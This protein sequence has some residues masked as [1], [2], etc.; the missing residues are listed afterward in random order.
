MSTR[1]SLEI[2]PD[3]AALVREKG[4][5]VYISVDGAGME[6]V[7]L[8][9]PHSHKQGVDWQ[10][11]DADGVHVFVDPGIESPSKWVLVLH[12]VPYRHIQALWDGT[13]IETSWTGGV[14]LSQEI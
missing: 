13:E 4:G 2:H 7:H 3:A 14:F 5:C 1:P 11:L 10:E 9:P 12:H 8:H 6:H